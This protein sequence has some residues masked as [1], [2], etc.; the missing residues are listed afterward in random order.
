LACTL[1]HKPSIIYLDEPTT[2]VDPVSRRDFW[3][4]LS[5]LLTQGITIVMNTPYMDEAERGARVAL[6][7][8]GSLLTVGTPQDIKNSLPYKVMEITTDDIRRDAIILK[9]FTSA[10]DVQ[11]FGDRVNVLCSDCAKLEK[12]IAKSGIKILSA[13]QIQPS[14]E[15]VFISTIQNR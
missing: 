8:Q 13:R 4:I 5:D 15:N 3:K 2:G 12:D 6:M 11:T 10:A 7:H 14:I 9:G 1:I